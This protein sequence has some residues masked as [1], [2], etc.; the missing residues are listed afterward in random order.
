MSFS[1]ISKSHNLR[2]AQATRAASAREES[3]QQKVPLSAAF[4]QL[5]DSLRDLQVIFV[6]I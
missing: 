4:V 6:Y 3:A 2:P 1:D 5:G